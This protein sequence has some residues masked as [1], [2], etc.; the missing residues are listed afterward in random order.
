MVTVVKSLDERRLQL[1]AL[2]DELGLA[3]RR[4]SDNAENTMQLQVRR[5]R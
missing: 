4:L 5:H 2:G 1:E 3:P